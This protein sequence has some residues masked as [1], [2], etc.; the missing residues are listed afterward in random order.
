MGNILRTIGSNVVNLILLVIFYVLVHTVLT[1]ATGAPPSHGL[2]NPI[3]DPAAFRLGM[4]TFLGAMILS[5]A[6]SGL[7]SHYFLRTP[8]A[9]AG[10]QSC[11]LLPMVILRNHLRMPPLAPGEPSHGVFI[12]CCLMTMLFGSLSAVLR[13]P[14]ASRGTQLYR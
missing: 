6:A 1:V 12:T 10:F 9:L 14:P 4:Y 2:P 13:A 7:L 11:C 8:P 3:T 5:G